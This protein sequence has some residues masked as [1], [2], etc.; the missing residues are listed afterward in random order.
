[1]KRRKPG[2]KPAEGEPMEMFALRLPASIVRGI[3]AAVREIQRERPDSP[4]TRTMA[5][6]VLLVEALQARKDA[7][8]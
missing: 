1:M 6:R 5:V 7:R 3:D 2:P 4:V 8:K